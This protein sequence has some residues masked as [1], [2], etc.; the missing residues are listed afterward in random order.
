MLGLEICKDILCLYS[1]N[2]LVVLLGQETLE[3][4]VKLPEEKLL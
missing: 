3:T 4:I 1:D 2:A